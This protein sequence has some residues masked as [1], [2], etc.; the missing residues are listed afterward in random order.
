MTILPKF[1]TRPSKKK[2]SWRRRHH[3]ST[4]LTRIMVRKLKNLILV[5]C[6]GLEICR[7]KHRRNLKAAIAMLLV[8]YDSLTC[9]EPELLAPL[10]RVERKYVTIDS[11]RDDQC[12]MYFRFETRE[13][14]RRVYRAFQFPTMFKDREKHKYSGEEVFLVGLYR[15]RN[16]STLAAACWEHFFGLTYIQVSSMFQLFLRFMVLNW[17]YLLT[18]N[19]A[20]WLPHLPVFAAAIRDKLA[21]KG[22]DIPH[23]QLP[24]GF[25]VFAFIDNTMNSTCRP[26]GG[27][28]RDGTNSP[29][30]NPLIQRAFYNGWKKLHALKWQTVDLP[31][32]MNFHVWGPCSGRHNDLESLEFSQLNDILVDM[33]MGNL[34]QWKIYGDSAY[35]FVPDTHIL[36]RH[37]DEPNTEEKIAQNKAMSSCREIIEWDYGDLG[38]YWSL[39]DYKK[40][41]KMR[42][43]PVQD[44]YLVAMLLR[45]AYVT[46]SGGNTSEYFNCLPPTLEA[47]VAAGPQAR[48]PTYFP[49][50]PDA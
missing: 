2:V 25:S 45:N 47:W 3:A 32:G 17:G 19:V 12:H 5:L 28:A 41:L 18:N 6:K 9:V 13:K 15:M 24:G 4:A 38:R 21:E 23:P 29:R 36:A 42:K 16:A 26:G 7:T 43:M 33:Q 22:V 46:V 40:V 10:H 1:H 48:P 27:P 8:K 20:F 11:L 14:L 39:V 50:P 30:N 49:P 34:L 35:I 44:M 31:N 37:N